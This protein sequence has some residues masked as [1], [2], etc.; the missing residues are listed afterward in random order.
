VR[1]LG[2][3]AGV[4]WSR[5]G[6]LF[7][8]TGDLDGFLQALRDEGVPYLVEKDRSY[9]RRREIIDA[10]A[11]VRTVLDCGDQLALVTW[12][13]SP[14]VGVPDAALVPL[15]LHGF[16]ELV[17]ELGPG[18]GVGQQLGAVIRQ[19]AR[20]MPSGISS[21]GRVAGWEDSLENAL[22]GLAELRSAWPEE[23][24]AR[25]VE[26]LRLTT[27]VEATEAARTLGAYRLVNLERF[28]RRLLGVL[29]DARG[30][31][32]VVLRFLRTAVSES[33][34][35]RGGRPREAG[36]DAVRVMTIHVAKGLDFDHVYLMQTHKQP[37]PGTD[38][39]TR[40]R[41]HE[42]GFET[43]LLGW[44]GPGW[45]QIEEQ[46]K[47]VAAAET[48]RTLYVA[49][50]RAKQRL[51]TVGSWPL[52]AKR[53]PRGSHLE[54]LRRRREL[55]DDLA[56]LA[57]RVAAHDGFVDAGQARWVFI[58]DEEPTHV[59]ARRSEAWRSLSPEEVARQSEK[60][61]ELKRQAE[62]RMRRPF[63]AAAS[64]E[65]HALL[66]E[67][68]AGIRSS[69]E[70]SGAKADRGVATAVGSV[71][72]RVL[73]VADLGRPEALP[74]LAE[75][76][77]PIMLEALSPP[78]LRDE[79]TQA[80]AE[81]TRRLASSKL[82]QRLQEIAP[83]AIAREVPVLLPPGMAAAPAAGYVA[84]KADLLYRDPKG[85]QLVVVD[86]KTDRMDGETEIGAR[87]AAYTTQGRTYAEAIQGALR[88]SSP[89]RVELWFLA[90]DRIV[91][92][93]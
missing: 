16:P 73:E 54:L 12:L 93:E 48:V 4:Q 82:G 90:A 77:A 70:Y 41:R 21:L 86:Y 64:A 39:D 11:L 31:R 34:E 27:L 66:D 14:S 10:A 51:V 81:L 85:G 52:A 53:P 45:L 30:D 74:A 20:D 29:D 6:I 49:L 38:S 59:A 43:Q 67:G 92:V 62:D 40:A 15:W 61:L 69:R 5:I 65:A 84:G 28:F 91:V 89:P 68:L 42:D 88:L 25:F 18:C 32:E 8:S 72:H 76:L 2:E 3:D 75:E 1:A 60:L 46:R 58:P 23:S 47:R 36:E 17:V 44:S 33:R 7:R 9:Y 56:A 50:T 35:E 71:I 24:V 19:A 57:D 55:P 78:A 63:S 80:V 87:A 83:A 22:A 37:R 13:R 79:A 26:R